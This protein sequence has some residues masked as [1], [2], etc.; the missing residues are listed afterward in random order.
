MLMDVYQV[1][2]L[3]LSIIVLCFSPRDMI[4]HRASVGHPRI[5]Q[6]QLDSFPLQYFEGYLWYIAEKF[7][8]VQ[9][10]FHNGIVISR[11]AT[12][13]SI[14][15]LTCWEVVHRLKGVEHKLLEKKHWSEV[16]MSTEMNGLLRWMT[17]RFWAS[18]FF[19][20]LHWPLLGLSLLSHLDKGPSG[21]GKYL[22]AWNIYTIT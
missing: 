15:T 8:V 9:I 21:A 12:R 6:P 4:S 16:N 11:L 7:M 19:Y 5:S 1:P 17:L 2:S 13:S 14:T 3:S 20:Y 18:L 10:K 22:Q